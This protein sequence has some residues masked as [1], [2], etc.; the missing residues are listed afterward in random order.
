MNA[1][2]ADEPPPLPVLD[3][4]DRTWRDY[5]G[6][7]SVGIMVAGLII[8][9]IL[10]SQV[11]AFTLHVVLLAVF[12]LGTVASAFC[13]LMGDALSRERQKRHRWAGFFNVTLLILNGVVLYGMA[14]FPGLIR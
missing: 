6:F 8:K 5:C 7:A 10:K 1:P 9:F 12:F 4:G 14:G 2:Q 3:S 13:L 11:S